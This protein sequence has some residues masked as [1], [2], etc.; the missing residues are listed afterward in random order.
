MDAEASARH[1]HY[2]PTTTTKPAKSVASSAPAVTRRSGSSKTIPT[3]QGGWLSTLTNLHARRYTETGLRNHDRDDLENE[4]WV[5]KREGKGVHHST[6]LSITEAKDKLW[7]VLAYFGLDYDIPAHGWQ[8]VVCPFHEDRTPSASV[9]Q[10]QFNCHACGVRGD[11]IDLI[12][13]QLGLEFNE[14]L[15]F[16]EEL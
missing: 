14:A 16:I 10:T 4:W 11:A 8:S 13:E 2:T 3:S 5:E 12:M 15:D 6:R 1:G 9:G 7:E